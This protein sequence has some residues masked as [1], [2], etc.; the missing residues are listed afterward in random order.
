[1]SLKRIPFTA[2]LE[3]VAQSRDM[4]A[5]SVL[6]LGCILKKDE[7]QA[8]IKIN[9]AEYK[10]WTGTKLQERQTFLSQDWSEAGAVRVDINFFR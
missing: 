1:V 9:A 4:T 3:K 8:C 7:A 6:P 5:L 10:L 2:V